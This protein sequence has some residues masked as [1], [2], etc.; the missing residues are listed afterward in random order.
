MYDN[1]YLRTLHFLDGK[2]MT[3][4]ADVD[5]G[6]NSELTK[7]VLDELKFNGFVA[8]YKDTVGIN[9]KGCAYLKQMASY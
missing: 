5:I 4:L 3:F 2:G 8:F 7:S 1:Y 9:G 6:L